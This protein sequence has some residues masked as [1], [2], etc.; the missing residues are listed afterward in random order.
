MVPNCHQYHLTYN[1]NQRI[2]QS[3]SCKDS[4]IQQTGLAQKEIPVVVLI[5]MALISTQ[6][7]HRV[8]SKRIGELVVSC[9]DDQEIKAHSLKGDMFRHFLRESVSEACL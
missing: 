3:S 6:D 5:T 2:A 1:L 8:S 9:M 7:F 4:Y